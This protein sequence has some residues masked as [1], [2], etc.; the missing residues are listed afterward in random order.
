MSRS[1][2]YIGLTKEARKFIEEHSEVTEV[3]FNNGYGN[4]KVYKPKT[5]IIGK[6][7]MFDEY[8]I[9]KYKLTDGS[10]AEEF[11]Q[12]QECCSGPIIFIGLK[13]DGIEF[14]W[15]LTE[16]NSYFN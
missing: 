4:C 10:Y 2:Q 12:F 9:V 6:C 16:I 11:I 15:T 14:L 5:E 7:G 1:T 13:Y 3:N 8:D